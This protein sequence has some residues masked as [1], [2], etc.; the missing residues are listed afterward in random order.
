MLPTSKQAEVLWLVDRLANRHVHVS[1]SMRSG[2]TLWGLWGFLNWAGE[3][4]SGHDFVIACKSHTQFQ[5]TLKAYM[6]D[7]AR[8]FGLGLSK[9][10]R[11]WALESAHGGY[12]FFYP[13]LYSGSASGGSG[14]GVGSTGGSLPASRIEGLTIAGAFIDEACECPQ[15]MLDTLSDRCSVPGAKLV[16]AYYPQSALHPLK[17]R[18]YDLVESGSLAGEIHH[19]PMEENPSLTVDY[20]EEQRRK[21]KPFPHEEARRIYGKWSSASGL[22]YDGFED[23]II[24]GGVPDEIAKWTVAVDWA[25]SSVCAAILVG[26]DYRSGCWYI[27]DEWGHDGRTDGVKTTEDKVTDLV[28]HMTRDGRKINEWI[29]DP[30]E[31]GLR[32]ELKRRQVGLVMDGVAEVEQGVK[33]AGQYLQS[34]KVKI[35]RYAC[36]RLLKD[37]STYSWDRKAAAVNKDR[38]D[39][40]SADGAH[41]AD[42]WRYY[43][44]T[45]WQSFS[46]RSP[47]VAGVAA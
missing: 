6:E 9:R 17:L 25:P 33:I 37:F 42:C 3:I 34:G 30:A 8:F 32:V 39:K 11:C 26:F 19:L 31:D 27:A 4:Y 2:K 23:A 21:W 45:H 12:N 15:I 22:I 16:Y 7:F 13:V 41:F 5:S 35:D 47:I 18:N 14:G 40:A 10:D 46:N 29:I 20:I 38:P 24:V 36:E 44:H 28:A 1:G 43:A